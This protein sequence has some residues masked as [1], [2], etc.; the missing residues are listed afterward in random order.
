[1]DDRPSTLHGYAAVTPLDT[2]RITFK[3]VE[4]MAALIHDCLVGIETLIN[5]EKRPSLFLNRGVLVSLAI[6]KLDLDDHVAEQG[7]SHIPRLAEIRDRIIDG[8]HADVIRHRLQILQLLRSAM[9]DAA[10]DW[11]DTMLGRWLMR[12]TDDIDAGFHLRVYD[13][14]TDIRCT[15]DA[16]PIDKHALRN[17]QNKIR[18]FLCVR[19]RV[20]VPVIGEDRNG[21]LGDQRTAALLYD[22]LQGLQALLHGRRN[23]GNILTRLVSLDA[24]DL[25]TEYGVGFDEEL[26]MARDIVCGILPGPSILTFE[27]A[28]RKFY[29]PALRTPGLILFFQDRKDL[30]TICEAVASEGPNI[31]EELDAARHALRTILDGLNDLSRAPATE[32]GRNGTSHNA[33]STTMT[34]QPHQSV[35][36]FVPGLVLDIEQSEDRTMFIAMNSQSESGPGQSQPTNPPPDLTVD[37]PPHSSTIIAGLNS[38]IG[39]DPFRDMFLWDIIF[40]PNTSRIFFNGQTYLPDLSQSAFYPETIR[41]VNFTTSHPLLKWWMNPGRWGPLKIDVHE[42]ITVRMVLEKMYEYLRTPMTVDEVSLMSGPNRTLLEWSRWNRN[43]DKI[44][45]QPPGRGDFLRSDVLGANRRFRGCTIC[46]EDGE[47]KVC[48]EFDMVQVPMWRR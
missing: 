41:S 40:V 35:V 28:L 8:T 42:P 16:F 32:N 1:M 30:Q 7:F 5:E 23:H 3:A 18:N 25:S 44:G 10:R 19:L 4:I 27:T 15:L 46:T 29:I 33:P 21:Q 14:V 37:A 20:G 13:L 24:D 17:H 47:Q 48:I 22:V 38:L 36:E 26:V 39:D 45:H 6:Q 9:W 43:G 12:T 31:L 34:G 11:T 2:K